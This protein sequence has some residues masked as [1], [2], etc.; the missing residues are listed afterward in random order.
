MWGRVGMGLSLAGW[1]AFPAVSIAQEVDQGAEA[2][3]EIVVTTPSPVAKP[4]PK[5]PKPTPSSPEPTSSQAKPKSNAPPVPAPSPPPVATQAPPPP[6]EENVAGGGGELAGPVII[7][8]D[9]FAPVTIATPRD[10]LARQGATLADTLMGKPGISGSTFAPGANR[11][12]IRGLDNYRVRVQEGGIGTHDASALSE[13]HAVPVDPFA[14]DR[15]EVV[16]GPAILRYGSQAIGGVVAI[17]NERIPTFIPDGGFSG[18]VKGGLSSVDN[19]N[20]GAM[21]VTAGG[22]ALVVHA[23]GFRRQ[24]DDYDTPRGRQLNSFVESEGGAAGASHVWDKG[25]IGLAYAHYES[26]YGIPGEEAAE[27]SPRIDL[28]QDKILARG[29]WRVQGLGV[30]ALRFW[31]G[32][33]SYIHEELA[34]HE[35]DEPEREVGSRF[36]NSE[37]EARAELQHQ[38]V[39]TPLGDLTGAIGVQWGHRRI[40]GLSLEGDS[41]LEPATTDMIAGFWFEELEVAAN[42]RLQFAARIEHNE[43]D[44]DGITDPLGA[45]PAVERFSRS[46][47]PI[48]GSLGLLYEFSAGVVGRATGQYVE[49]AADAAELFSKGVH[50]AT[51]T[52]EIGN[53]L[54]ATEKATAFELGLKRATGA[55]RFDT[56]LFYTRYDGFIFKELTGVTCGETLGSCGV[57]DEL[58]QLVFGQRDA[59][60]Y[61]LE[62]AGILDVARI[63][64]GTFGIDGQYDFVDAEFSTGENIQRIP[65]HR[66]GGGLFYQDPGW[67]ARIGV[68][69][70]FDQN[71]IGD[72]ETP[73]DGYTLVSA[74]ISHTLRFNESGAGPARMIVGLRG[75]NLLDEE[76]RNHASFKKDEVLQPGASVR[77]FGSVKLN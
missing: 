32:T 65:P 11:P 45:S 61:G 41:L 39:A 6:Q 63:G 62:L 23:D 36:T 25:F 1:A 66:L 58:D 30:E 50:E 59:R 52:F 54:L 40:E 7:A 64:R 60:F 3:P 42:L 56:S 57:E 70:A 74:E 14:A 38:T 4:R 73:T 28:N 2:L 47:M 35:P 8:E 46:F 69:H 29:E 22:D 48:S 10:V 33:S 24:L 55:F 76:V 37:K 43:V 13:D 51:G 16:R 21:S 72:N 27:E 12:V 67:F 68:L 15:I 31:F 34:F 19:G 26:L 49:R 5:R 9:A 53:P 17:E 71:E 44:G 75:D 20:D 18:E 77:L